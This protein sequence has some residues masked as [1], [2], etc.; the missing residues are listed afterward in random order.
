MAGA[1][2]RIE[3]NI[4]LILIT[5]AI[6]SFGAGVGVYSFILGTPRFRTAGES[7][8]PKPT[9]VGSSSPT[10]ATMVPPVQIFTLPVTATKPH[11]VAHFDIAKY[12]S[13]NRQGPTPEIQKLRDESKLEQFVSAS[14]LQ[15]LFDAPVATYT[16]VAT[17]NLT[18]RVDESFA[19]LWRGPVL[20]SYGDRADIFEIH[21]VTANEAMLLAYVSESDARELSELT[22]KRLVQVTL[23]PIPSREASELVVVPLNR[24]VTSKVRYTRFSHLAVLDISMV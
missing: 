12:A 19:R 2:E 5:C 22:G 14:A 24:I 15:A 3:N 17:P 20:K 11:R 21:R 4:A 1:R 9:D 16:F 23:V 13:L 7:A 8:A 10:L 6:S 18:K